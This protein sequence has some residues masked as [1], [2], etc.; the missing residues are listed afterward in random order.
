MIRRADTALL[1]AKGSGRN[2]VVIAEP[3]RDTAAPKDAEAIAVADLV[4]EHI[5]IDAANDALAQP[6]CKPLAD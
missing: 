4:R 5:G 6:D 3:T 1:D 2:R